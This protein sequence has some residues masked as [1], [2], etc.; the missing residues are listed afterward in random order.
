MDEAYQLRSDVLLP[1]AGRFG[2]ALF[3]G[4]PVQLDLFSTHPL[5]GPDLGPNAVSGG[6]TAATQFGTTGPP[7]AGVLAVARVCGAAAPPEVSPPPT[8]DGGYQP[9]SRYGHDERAHLRCVGLWALA[10]TA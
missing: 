6:G 2:R 5:G 10:A 3:V 4:D 7:A 9:F 1:V 8:F